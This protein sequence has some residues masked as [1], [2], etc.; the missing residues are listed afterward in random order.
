MIMSFTALT[1]MA[2]T[3]S[4]VP[5]PDCQGEGQAVPEICQVLTDQ[6]NAWNAGDIAGFM[7]GYLNSEALRFA[8]GGTITTGWQ[9]T[10]ERY[11]NRYDSPEAM[12]QLG[13][14]DLDITQLS[15]ERAY[16]F[17]RWTLYRGADEPTGL[18]TLI[19]LQTPEGWRVVHDH[20]SSASE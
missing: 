20:T 15:Q 5:A 7:A 10:L 2:L 11:L 13:F 6:Q 9:P 1:L 4:E 18:F 3:V 14:S 19:L 16:V 8:S 17:G 12:G